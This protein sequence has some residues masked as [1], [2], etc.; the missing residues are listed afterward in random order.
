V[1]MS[2]RR[3]LDGAS[4]GQVD[5]LSAAG[6]CGSSGAVSTGRARISRRATGRPC[7]LS[8]AVYR[9]VPSGSTLASSRDVRMKRIGPIG[10]STWYGAIR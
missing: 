7:Q 8:R 9:S 10:A 1:I 4:A 6:M 2:G 5:P 3:K